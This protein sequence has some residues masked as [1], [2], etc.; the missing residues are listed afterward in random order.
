MLFNGSGKEPF[1][2]GNIPV[3]AQQAIDCQ[4]AMIDSTIQVRP[5]ASDSDVRFVHT[6]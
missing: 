1:S 6:P 2:C 5:P 3:F 4:A